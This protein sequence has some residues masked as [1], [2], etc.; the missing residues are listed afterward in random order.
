MGTGNRTL[1][2][3]MTFPE[4]PSFREGLLG[5]W[6]CAQIAWAIIFMEVS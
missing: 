4:A 6:P 5:V 1:F 3:T 2:I